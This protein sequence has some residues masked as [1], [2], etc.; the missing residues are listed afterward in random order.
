MKPV[1]FLLVSLLT[2][3]V[4]SENELPAQLLIKGNY[5][6]NTHQDSAAIYFYEE[7]Y[8]L[9]TESIILQELYASCLIKTSK[10]SSGLPILRKVINSY[11]KNEN[12]KKALILMRQVYGITTSYCDGCTLAL[13]T[14]K[15]GLREKDLIKMKKANTIWRYLSQRATKNNQLD[16]L[17]YVLEFQ[18]KITNSK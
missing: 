12:W 1:V 17:N 3:S 11:I 4:F 9:D 8:K 16:S 15:W 2:V 6:N 10:Y 7:A 13:I 5:F 14:Y 18:R